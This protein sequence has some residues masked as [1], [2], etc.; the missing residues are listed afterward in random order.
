MPILTPRDPA[1]GTRLNLVVSRE[2]ADKIG[3]GLNWEA[4]ILDLSSGY[5]YR[6]TGLSCALPDCNCDSVV[7]FRMEPLKQ[8]PDAVAER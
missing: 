8:R 2:D 5:R 1:S 7:V 3:R 6:L 4:D